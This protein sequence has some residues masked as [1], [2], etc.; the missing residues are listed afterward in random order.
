MKKVFSPL[1]MIEDDEI[2]NSEKPLD[3]AKV[4]ID[5]NKSYFNFAKGAIVE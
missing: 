4:V 5:Q 1:M 2:N 3:K